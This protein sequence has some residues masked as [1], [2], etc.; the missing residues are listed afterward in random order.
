[1]LG[2]A[3]YTGGQGGGWRDAL[4]GEVAQG[5]LAVGVGR[6]RVVGQG[7]DACLHFGR[8]ALV[9][10]GYHGDVGT[11][12]TFRGSV[13]AGGADC[14]CTVLRRGWLGAVERPLFPEVLQLAA[15]ATACGEAV[16]EAG[17]LG[18]VQVLLMTLGA[19]GHIVLSDALAFGEVAEVVEGVHGCKLVES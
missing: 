10:G 5:G 4:M 11:R 16:H 8:Q 19:L 18:D 12:R 9:V 1:M 13:Q 3:A 14:R 2:Q 15:E 6:L 17:G 7:L